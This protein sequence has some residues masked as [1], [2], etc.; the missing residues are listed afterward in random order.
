[1]ARG[2]QLPLPAGA[3]AMQPLLQPPLLLLPWL[4][5]ELVA[6]GQA[7]GCRPCRRSLSPLLPLPLVRNQPCACLFSSR[8]VG[9]K[10][11]LGT[12]RL[13]GCGVVGGRPG[14]GN[15]K[16]AGQP[17]SATSARSRHADG[18][19]AL[20]WAGPARSQAKRWKHS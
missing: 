14:T 7:E 12:K 10:R 17:C 18:C 2:L 20:R 5:A 4:L 3:P 11:Q 8:H 15:Q 19:H 1:M 13:L 6:A 9:H 16:P